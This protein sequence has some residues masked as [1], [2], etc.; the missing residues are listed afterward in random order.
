MLRA[1]REHC[2]QCR[3]VA[4]Q[5][6]E[7]WISQHSFEKSLLAAV[8]RVD[9]MHAGFGWRIAISCASWAQRGFEL[10]KLFVLLRNVF[11]R[12]RT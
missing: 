2:A 6:R 10:A 7:Q 1:R 12:S 8:A 11:V 4:A 5:L 3:H 9:A